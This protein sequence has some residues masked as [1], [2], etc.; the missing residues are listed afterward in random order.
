M[1]YEINLIQ[2]VLPSY[3]I[4]SMY[5]DNSTALRYDE[6]LV[7]RLK[8]IA[9]DSHASVVVPDPDNKFTISDLDKFSVDPIDLHDII[10]IRNTETDD[11]VI[12]DFQDGPKHSKTL[13]KNSNCILHYSCMFLDMVDKDT[14]AFDANCDLLPFTFFDNYPNLTRKY[15]EE[16]QSIRNRGEFIPKMVFY[17]TLGDLESD[18][19]CTY[20]A[21][22]GEREETRLV[23]KILHEK[24]P[25]LI[26]IKDREEKLERTEWWKLAATYSLALT[27]PGHPWCSR[28]HEFWSLGI[29]TIASTYTC[30]LLFPLIHNK[31]YVD[32]GT[33]G[34]DFMDREIDQEQA[35]DLIAQ[36][37]LEVRDHPE[38]LKK[39]AK[40]A[41]I[42]YDTFIHPVKAAEHLIA[43][44]KFRTEFL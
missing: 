30:P 29:P 44:I 26:D 20:N 21:I 17:G 35:A 2:P 28:E 32:A 8:E 7:Q 25:E 31:H 42:R 12:L 33:T 3:D 24:Y 4:G 11:Y 13:V 14:T 5:I 6:I 10:I 9:S 34:K 36:R 41:Q 37:F 38:Y 19:Y 27:V 18:V 15:R 40:N 39:L 43:D 23:V 1:S 16:I 22:T